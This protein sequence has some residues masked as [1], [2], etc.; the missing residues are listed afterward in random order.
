MREGGRASAVSIPSGGSPPTLRS[1]PRRQ[2][3]GLCVTCQTA[4]AIFE[5]ECF[6]CAL[7]R[8][9]SVN[10]RAVTS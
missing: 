9:T 10:R 7:D 2:S 5:G 8:L 6:D 1:E 3:L 4:D